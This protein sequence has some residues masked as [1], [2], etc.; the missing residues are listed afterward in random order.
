[1][2]D[3]IKSYALFFFMAIFFISGCDSNRAPLFGNTKGYTFI[4]PEFS[5]IP[6]V[7]SLV[8]SLIKYENGEEIDVTKDADWSVS[9][10]DSFIA[11]NNNEVTGIEQ[12]LARVTASYL[13][14]KYVA[15]VN[16]TGAITSI[17]IEVEYPAVPV[18]VE[19]NL[20][21]M[22]ATENNVAVDITALSDI[23]SNMGTVIG[24]QGEY[25]PTQAGT[26][27]ITANYKSINDQT[28]IYVIDAYPLNIV[29]K[30]Q[31]LN[32][33][34]SYQFS[35]SATGLFSNGLEYDLT[36]SASWR[37]TSGSVEYLYGPHFLAK[38]IG[39]AELIAE[40]GPVNSS[41]TA[42]VKGL[43]EI[44]VSIETTPSQKSMWVGRELKLNT[45]AKFDKE[46]VDVTKFTRYLSNDL[47]VL[48]PV[49][50]N[51]FV[52]IAE[53]NTEVQA[54]Y[55]E[56]S[57]LIP[58]EV[59]SGQPEG[60]LTVTPGA[61]SINKGGTG[62]LQA[63]VMFNSNLVDVTDE[64]KW[65]SEDN[66]TVMVSNLG[67]IYGVNVTSST[68]VY[69]NYANLTESS[70]Q[71]TVLDGE[72]DYDYFISHNGGPLEPSTPYSITKDDGYQLRLVRIDK[73]NPDSQNIMIT[74][75]WSSNNPEIAVSDNGLVTGRTSGAQGTITTSYYDVD[76]HKIEE[77]V[78]VQV[79]DAIGTLT[80]ERQ[81]GDETI[82]PIDYYENSTDDSYVYVLKNDGVE[83][84]RDVIWEVS[85]G[86]ASIT[87][88]ASRATVTPDK[89]GIITLTASYQ[90]QD[91]DLDITSRK[92]TELNIYIDDVKINDN[93]E[94]DLYAAKDIKVDLKAKYTTNGASYSEEY[95]NIE[96][97]FNSSS[98]IKYTNSESEHSRI[99]LPSSSDNPPW[100]RYSY[101]E[102]LNYS[103]GGITQSF[104]AKLA[105]GYYN[106]FDV[107]YIAYKDTEFKKVSEITYKLMYP[108]ESCAIDE[109]TNNND[110][111]VDLNAYLA[112]LN[113]GFNENM[114]PNDPL[115]YGWIMEGTIGPGLSNSAYLIDILGNNSNA[116]SSDINDHYSI[117]KKGLN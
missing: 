91:I 32:V 81:S 5:N 2:R 110:I 55:Q 92:L 98:D 77:S 75:T 61:T 4:S 87:Q 41:S 93:D 76:Q 70:S 40:F 51:E 25:K 45:I 115:E 101:N 90:G 52:A 29:T 64:V 16:V 31:E 102:F 46:S 27:T 105:N 13:G 28:D 71:V 39:D 100:A 47:E 1:M 104:K 84:L 35:L 54:N 30:P 10:G 9:S 108:D 63:Q 95:K 85:S 43:D 80:I 57:N 114:W 15:I 34:L 106:G 73:N 44:D 68:Q 113:I 99:I 88:N 78:T 103:F 11:L 72:P 56:W 97:L 23:S 36:D 116:T 20:K 17:W 24:E 7:D 19:Q 50:S 33:P 83:V 69:A 65:S 67:V 74:N 109:Y 48:S 18:N 62:S 22:G 86:P 94:I 60:D 6:V 38:T 117:C 42:H 66:S 111:L 14:E 79:S 107:V 26:E 82:Y 53:G 89:Y 96:P 112:G 12:G 59:L 49:Q 3:F 8:L 58:V 37:S 21:V